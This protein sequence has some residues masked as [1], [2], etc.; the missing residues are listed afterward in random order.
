MV[1]NLGAVGLAGMRFQMLHK[2]VEVAHRHSNTLV[3]M[4]CRFVQ[5]FRCL[6]LLVRMC[7]ARQPCFIYTGSMLKAGQLERWV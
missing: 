7:K 5:H 2:C 6:M 4:S 3:N 1:L